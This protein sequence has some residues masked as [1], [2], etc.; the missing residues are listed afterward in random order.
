M[1]A[2]TS[3]LLETDMFSA[4]APAHLLLNLASDSSHGH[5]NQ[6]QEGCWAKLRRLT[7]HG[8]PFRILSCKGHRTHRSRKSLRHRL[9]VPVRH[10]GIYSPSVRNMNVVKK[11]LDEHDQPQIPLRQSTASWLHRLN[12]VACRGWGNSED[13]KVQKLS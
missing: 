6:A 3:S 11:K 8:M 13:I 4:F 5:W 7:A 2:H 12:C 9:H 10:D 1:V